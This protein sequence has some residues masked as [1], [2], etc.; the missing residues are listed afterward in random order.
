MYNTHIVPVDKV[1][2][3]WPLV[4]PFITVSLEKSDSIFN[5]DKVCELVV[6][7]LWKLVI[8]YD[9]DNIIHGAA[10]VQIIPTPKDVV[11]FVTCIGG[12]LVSDKQTFENFKEILRKE[13][14]TEIQGTV[15]PSIQRLW[16]RLGFSDKYTVVGVSI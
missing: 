10:V 3:V 2:V 11:G 13:G 12:R 5:L 6:S 9:E 14:I 15:R 1:G 8:A 4:L 7:G 16:K